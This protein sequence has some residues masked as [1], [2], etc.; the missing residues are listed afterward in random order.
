M[1]CGTAGAGTAL[2]GGVLYR[3]SPHVALGAEA[4]WFQFR[5]DNASAPTAYSNA[6]WLGF[7]IRGYFLDRSALDPYVETGV[8]RGAA[9]AGHMSGTDD[10]RTEAAGPSVVASA[11]IDFWIA[12]YLRVGPAFAYRW[13]W[14][15]SVSSC[16]TSACATV[17]LAER[18]AIGSS[19]SLSLLATIAL[20]QQM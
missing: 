13:T 8:G 11:G 2:G 19:A 12:P 15:T 17:S 9:S 4:S 18:G 3:V 14:L 7:I 20:G 1:L 10:A 5:P 6:S 16:Q